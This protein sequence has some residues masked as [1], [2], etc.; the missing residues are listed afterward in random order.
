M[1]YPAFAIVMG[2]LAFFWVA[3]LGLLWRRS[4]IGMLLGVLFGWLSTVIVGIGWV[5]GR[6]GTAETGD[7]AVL[8]IVFAL[9]G[10]LQVAL[11]IAIVVAR[12]VRR[13]SLD[14]QDAVLLEG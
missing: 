9:V 12:V 3:M 13:G 7:G 4:L 6:S 11:G 1:A 10:A 2:G 5:V 14:V 8:L